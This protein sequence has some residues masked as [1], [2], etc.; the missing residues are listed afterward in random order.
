[1]PVAKLF[2]VAATSKPQSKRDVPKPY[3]MAF[4][5]PAQMPEGFAEARVKGTG[6]TPNLPAGMSLVWS[7]T[8]DAWRTF[9]LLG[10]QELTST[11]FD[12]DNFDAACQGHKLAL[13]VLSPEERVVWGLDK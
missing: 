8:H 9:N 10:V 6:K 4:V 11:D 5:H 3:K 7:I 12:T 1:M 2:I 13:S